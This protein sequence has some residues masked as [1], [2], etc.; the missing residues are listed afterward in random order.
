M[1]DRNKEKITVDEKE[2]MLDIAVLLKSLSPT[3]KER[4]RYLIQGINLKDEVVKAK[5]APTR[6]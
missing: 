6:A 3:E 1:S 5:G 2:E 4:I